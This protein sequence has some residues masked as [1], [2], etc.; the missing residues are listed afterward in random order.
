MGS[1]RIRKAPGLALSQWGDTAEVEM[2]SWDK[3]L[4]VTIPLQA[5]HFFVISVAN[6]H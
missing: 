5:L 1:H 3:A 2:I 6:T 4:L